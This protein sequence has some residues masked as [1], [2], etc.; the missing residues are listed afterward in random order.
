M[1]RNVV[2]NDAYTRIIDNKR[3][4]EFY[5]ENSKKLNVN[6]ELIEIQHLQKK[7]FMHVIKAYPSKYNEKDVILESREITTEVNYTF[8]DLNYN[9]TYNAELKPEISNHFYFYKLD[10]NNNKV[11]VTEVN[12]LVVGADIFDGYDLATA[13]HDGS[14]GIDTY[15]YTLVNNV[16]YNNLVDSRFFLKDTVLNT[17][18]ANT[19]DVSEA[20]ELYVNV[21]NTT[22]NTFYIFRVICLW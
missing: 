6:R 8:A 20:V 19:A 12:P 21:K 22:R 15:E 1:L 5:L 16:K 18:I 3:N 4:K 11:K 17:T 13:L 10:N 9:N 2:F 7:I 14:N